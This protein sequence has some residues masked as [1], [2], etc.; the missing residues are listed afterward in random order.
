[1]AKRDYEKLEIAEFGHHLLDTNDLDPVYVALRDLMQQNVWTEAQVKRFLVAYWC[2]YDCGVASYLSEWVE[3]AYWER[4]WHAAKNETTA[5]TGGRWSRGKERRHFRGEQAKN[6][7]YELKGRY[8]TAGDMVD[9]VA[10]GWNPSTV[11][12]VFNRVQQHRGFGPWISFKIADM[13]ET[14]F[15]LPVDFTEGVIFMFKDPAKAA[16][17][18][19][20]RYYADE[21]LNVT[22]VRDRR[23]RVVADLVEE[24][25]D[26]NAPP[27]H[28]RPIGIQEVET[29]LC[30]WKSHQRGHYPLNND[31]VEIREALQPW[32]EHS[33][34]AAAFLN[35]MP[36]P[37]ENNN[38]E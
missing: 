25:G 29:I 4:M 36:I 31:L 37:K 7:M 3:G 19:W 23:S 11:E 10:G 38:D 20:D 21:S 8:A 22:T 1:M 9:F 26:R 28:S 33:E 34:S 12:E 6:A 27:G 17:M 24:Y 13:L 2:F 32:L 35:A 5:P 30:K 14:V 15:E 16:D 18:V